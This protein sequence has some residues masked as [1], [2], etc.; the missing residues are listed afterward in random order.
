M[1]LAMVGL[2]KMGMGMTERLLQKGHTVVAFDLVPATV[3]TAADKGAVPATTFEEIAA[4]LESPRIVWIMVPAGDPVGETIRQL[5]PLL[6]PG[7]V[8]IDGGNSHY[9]DSIERAS[10]LAAK[11]IHFLDTGVSG[12]VWGLVNGFNLMIGGDANAFELVE[13]IYKDLAAA[14]GYMLVGPSGSGHYVKM[15][16]NG[17]EYG[18]MQAYAEGYDLIRAKTEFNVDLAKLTRLWM[19]GSVIRSWLLE[20]AGNALE[21]DPNLEWVS[22]MVLDSGEGRWTVVEAIDLS[23]PIPVISL[24]LQTR[25][26]SRQKDMF[27][28]RLLSALRNQFGGHPVRKEGEGE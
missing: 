24:S 10:M 25:F 16:H 13:P 15:I 18:M 2:G 5:E 21:E 9:K 22:P 14:G 26:R 27:G 23:V 19:N 4:K 20:L 11:G 3:Q 28:A 7:D 8:V 12:G 17:I 6:S 1:K